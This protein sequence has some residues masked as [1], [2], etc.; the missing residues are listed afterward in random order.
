MA[1]R[2]SVYKLLYVV[3]IAWLIAVH[4][5]KKVESVRSFNIGH[6]VVGL[7]GTRRSASPPS[8]FGFERT[9]KRRVRRGSDPIHN[10][11]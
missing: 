10:R 9:N 1:S 2:N 5:V 4:A 7:D 8:S 11:C 3:V 6:Q